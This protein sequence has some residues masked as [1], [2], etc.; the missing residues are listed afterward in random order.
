LH[1]IQ[2]QPS[3][4][5][6]TPDYDL[7]SWGI[8]LLYKHVEILRSHN[9]NAFVLHHNSGFSIDWLEANVPIAFLDDPSIEIRSDDMLV[10]PELLAREGITVGG[11]CRRTVFVQGSYFVLQPFNEAISY[12]DLGYETAIAVLPH[13]KDVLERHF[14]ITATVVPPFIAPYF[15]CD[16]RGS[17]GHSRQQRI[18]MFPKLGYREAGIFDYEIIRKLL[19]RDCRQNP[20]W[21]LLEVSGRPHREVAALMQNSEFMV[22]VNCLEAF[23]TTVPEAM[24][25]GCLPICYEGFGGQDFLVDDQNAFVFPN[26]YVYSL[27]DT[28]KEM[29]VAFEKN[30]SLL[31]EMRTN[32]RLTASTYSEENTKRALVALF[33]DLGY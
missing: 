2:M 9:V 29:M 6:L 11:N 13:V 19:Q 24:A 18:L 15:F 30:S 27:A 21:E 31:A 7:P 10:V 17:E 4:Y 3:V 28:A 22:S 16:E 14:D 8:G 12:R 20:P 23:N 32:A 26:N 1:Q 33:G 25:A 5:Y